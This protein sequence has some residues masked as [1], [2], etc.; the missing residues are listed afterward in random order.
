MPKKV[1][2]KAERHAAIVKNLQSNIYEDRNPSITA[3]RRLAVERWVR[4]YIRHVEYLEDGE[5]QFLYNVF[6]DENCWLGARLNNT[7]LGQKLTEEKASEIENPFSRYDMACRYCIVDEI[8]KFFDEQFDSYKQGFSSGLDDDSKPVTDEYIRKELLDYMGSQDPVLSFWINKD[9]GKFQNPQNNEECFQRALELEWSEGLDY[10]SHRLRQQGKDSTNLLIKTITELS[11][12]QTKES[13]AAIL[14]FCL[15]NIGNKN[16]LLDELSRKDRGVYSLFRIL[17]RWSF[18]DTIQ[19]IIP[20]FKD[21]MLEGKMLS[22]Q[23]YALLLSLLSDKVIESTTLGYQARKIM[24]NLIKC[25]NFSIQEGKEEKAA[26]FFCGG[27]VPIDHALSGLIID[28]VNDNET[29]ST[30]DVKKDEILEILQFAKKFC[31]DTDF[32]NFKKSI[33]NNL[34]MVSRHGMKDDMNYDKFAEKLF[35][36]LE[37]KVSPY[38]QGGDFC[39]SGS[40]KS[41]LGGAGVSG[42]SYH[43]K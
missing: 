41:V 1:S 24:M 31:S 21:K 11:G 33:V 19:D 12:A 15:R 34:N 38:S 8:Q 26:V 18:F 10:F 25:G 3:G 20:I 4:T 43:R 13:I 17:V 42:F 39:S 23:D 16:P 9:S 35:S 40:P 30:R 27:I 2:R 37:K 14:D 36:E 28:W 6:R 5:L 29:D 22:P 7:M 32:G